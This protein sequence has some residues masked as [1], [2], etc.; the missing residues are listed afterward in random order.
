MRDGHDVVV[1]SRAPQ[2]APWRVVAWDA[3]AVGDRAEIDGADVVINPAGRSV[4]C[5]YTPRNRDLIMNSRIDAT[6]AIANAIANAIK[7]PRV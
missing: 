3:R 4:N 5:R 7:P 6:R 1:L 2:G